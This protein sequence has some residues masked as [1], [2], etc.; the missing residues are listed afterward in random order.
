MNISG[1][2]VSLFLNWTLPW[3]WKW[4]NSFY[5]QVEIYRERSCLDKDGYC[6]IVAKAVAKHLHSYS[7]YAGEKGKKHKTIML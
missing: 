3:S 2:F 6:W 7:K 5:R 1:V 4:V